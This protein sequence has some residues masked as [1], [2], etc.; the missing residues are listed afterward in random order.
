MSTLADWE[1]KSLAKELVQ[2]MAKRDP[3]E[4]VSAT[5]AL[6]QVKA[7]CKTL[8][9]TDSDESLFEATGSI[10]DLDAIMDG[11]TASDSTTAPDTPPTIVVTL[12]D[13]VDLRPTPHFPED[14]SLLTAPGPKL[15]RRRR[16]SMEMAEWVIIGSKADPIPWCPRV[17][18]GRA[19]RV[20]IRAQLTVASF[21]R[22]VQAWYEVKKGTLQD[23]LHNLRRK[24]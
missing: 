2:A 15:S 9:G 7:L 14:S 23:E 4:R 24:A 1:A 10:T 13:D 11:I 22:K 16:E 17:I 12:W 3:L 6:K 20:K 18:P 8:G 5:E 19:R 21:K